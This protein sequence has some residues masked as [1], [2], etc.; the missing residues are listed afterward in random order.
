MTGPDTVMLAWHELELGLFFHWDIEVFQPE[1]DGTPEHLPEPD[2]FRPSALDIE[3]WMDTAVSSGAR[4][5]LITAKHDTGFCLWPT[6]VH[7]YHV[8]TAGCPDIVGLF[9]RACRERGIVP[10]VYYSLRG[11]YL[12]KMCR[13]ASGNLDRIM[14]NDLLVRQLNELLDTYGPFG[15]I[16]FDG[17]IRRMDLGGPNLVELIRKKAADT[18]IFGGCPGMDHVLRWSGSEQGI[19]LP[20]TWST[21]HW[22]SEPWGNITC[23][24]PG[25]SEDEVW[26]PVEVDTPIR[27]NLCAWMGGWFWKAGEEHLTVPETILFERYLTSVGRNSN[28][29]IG[30]TPDTRGQI[31]ED[32]CR[33]LTG[34]GRRV[35]EAFSTP[36][37]ISET[38]TGTSMEIRFPEMMDIEYVDI[39][40]DQTLG[41]HVLE[42][43]VEILW[44]KSWCTEGERWIEVFRGKS[45]GHRRIVPLGIIRA[46]AVRVRILSWKGEA[47]LRCFRAF[48]SRS[49]QEEKKS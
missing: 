37:G 30:V 13:D 32:E 46:E 20:D 47:V 24:A 33:S 34:L 44:P 1:W 49:L 15:E 42:F 11:K 10:G 40:E 21:S 23:D 8:G 48:G 36:A 39:W 26:A 43:A 18:V 22:R 41:Q 9:V 35:R 17:G 2:V 19:A 31:P 5:A 3:Q 16:W 12:E 6:R 4:Y 38:M 45:I 28:M 29:L 14:L 7:D 25:S 27:E